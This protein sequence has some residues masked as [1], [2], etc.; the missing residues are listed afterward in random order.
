MQYDSLNSFRKLESHIG[1]TDVHL[2]LGLKSVP[3]LTYLHCALVLDSPNISAHLLKCGANLAGETE[4]HPD[5]TPLCLAL[6]R[7]GTSSQK[8]LDFALRVAC[9]YAL[10]R[11]VTVLLTRGANAN[12]RSLFGLAAVHCAV[13]PRAPWRT[14]DV[15]HS[16][17][18]RRSRYEQEPKEK[19]WE[20]WV[21]KTVKALI[22]FGVDIDHRAKTTR[23]HSCDH[24]C[25]RSMNC[26][27][28]GQTPLHLASAS[29]FPK[30]M[31][32]LLDHGA[33]ANSPNDD[34]YT[35]LYWA[36]AQDREKAAQLL[37]EYHD[38]LNPL[39]NEDSRL[40]ALHVACRF[41]LSQIVSDLLEKNI[42]PN[43][44]DSR[45]RTPLHEVLSQTRMG[46][47]DDVIST[48]VHLEKAGVNP[49]IK[50]ADGLD[51][52]QIAADHPFRRVREMFLP[53]VDDASFAIDPAA[54]RIGTAEYLWSSDSIF[55]FSRGRYSP[56]GCIVERQSPS[57]TPVENNLQNFPALGESSEPS[58]WSSSG[59]AT[60]NGTAHCTS[61]SW[62][63]GET[64]D[65]AYSSTVSND[66][67]H[68]FVSTVNSQPVNGAAQAVWRPE[69]TARLRRALQTVPQS[70]SNV[71]TSCDPF[72][73]L[74][75]TV[76]TNSTARTQA[77]DTWSKFR[78]SAHLIT[79][80]NL[81]ATEEVPVTVNKKTRKGKKNKWS[82]LAL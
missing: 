8:E 56:V 1:L 37:L 45:G 72:P 57:Y 28:R 33:V 62:S 66:L 39:V 30:V 36:L 12:A 38:D 76:L 49:D 9:N 81:E 34:G 41:A 19:V 69:D 55:T 77:A 4:D 51:V 24:T 15:F 3:G 42:D 74:T 73:S 60:T 50:A 52:R 29:G 48:L 27:H 5:L 21:Y 7:S 10:P 20:L 78:S 46:R 40:T 31:R 6:A 18:K 44:I 82:P 59:I 64:M 61:I 71:T 75:T 22:W 65:T 25:Y 32:L 43:V 68:P 70:E 54:L 35:P 47:E 58:T 26:S 67:S 14:D 80:S 16:L 17:S 2:V 13:M 23:S 63:E 53:V 79:D 11:I